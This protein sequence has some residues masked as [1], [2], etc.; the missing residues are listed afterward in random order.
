[1][2][3]RR[4]YVGLALLVA[5]AGCADPAST[6]ASDVAT[7][8][9]SP[10]ATPSTSPSASQT[11]TA[12]PSGLAGVP[13]ADGYPEVNGNDQNPV[14]VTETSGLTDLVLCDRTAWS[15]GD[16]VPAAD[17][18]G[19]TYTGEAEDI[20]ARTL[21][22]YDSS[23]D[24]QGA[25]AALRDVVAS[26]ALE[27]V[28]GTAQVYS[29]HDLAAGQEA[30]L[31]MHRYR[32]DYGFDTGLELIGV[33]RVGDMLLLDLLYGEGGGSPETIAASQRFRFRAAAGVVAAMCELAGPC[34]ERTPA[35]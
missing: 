22:R 26:C 15:P 3:T 16:P 5:L 7:S 8:S 27:T 10:S 4:E 11:P 9:A 25:L 19:A 18:I 2:R 31:V 34:P 29:I 6:V 23:G 33:V 14:E 32:S 30:F 20:R 12:S 35:G 28:G 17:L 21:A 13:L 24:A 1:V